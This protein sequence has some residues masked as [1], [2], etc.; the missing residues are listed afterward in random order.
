MSAGLAA[1]VNWSRIT[2]DPAVLSRS[3][4]AGSFSPSWDGC[5]AGPAV[6]A[7]A[8]IPSSR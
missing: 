4:P 7:A 1:L 5:R 8:V 3:G 2:A 6:A